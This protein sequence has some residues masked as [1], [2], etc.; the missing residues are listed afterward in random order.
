MLNLV[1]DVDVEWSLGHPRKT[2]GQQLG[3]Y[4]E[5]RNQDDVQ[6]GT[7]SWMDKITQGDGVT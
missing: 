2:C 5:Y 6:T 3:L 4:M 7:E 1:L